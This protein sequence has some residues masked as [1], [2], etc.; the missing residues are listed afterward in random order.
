MIPVTINVILIGFG[1]S[2]AWDRRKFLGLSPLFGGIGYYL[3]NAIVRNSGGRYT[4][5]V[6]WIGIFYYSLGIMYITF[7]LL[8]YFRKKDL[9]FDRN[10]KTQR[11]GTKDDLPIFSFSNLWITLG[12]FLFGCILPV[13]EKAIPPKFDTATSEQ[14]LFDL[15]YAANPLLTGVEQNIVSSFLFS[16]GTYLNGLALYPRYHKPYQMGSVWNY[17]QDR[18]FAHLD[19]Y[20]SSPRD[21]GIVLPID[22]PPNSFPHATEVL[23]LACPQED[24]YDALLIVLY[25]DEGQPNEIIWRSTFLEVTSCPLPPPRN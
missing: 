6:N 17:Y 8:S 12:L 5:P 18:P 22:T 14:K 25:S 16:G 1:I 21:S 4:V 2:V 19:F 9:Q 15:L 11:D 10:V 7:W 24:Y 13:L 23:V 20:L 3:V